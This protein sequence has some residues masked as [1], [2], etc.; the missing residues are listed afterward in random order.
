MNK[1]D[2]N[3]VGTVV[4]QSAIEVHR[5][6]GNGLL[7]SVYEAALGI[8]LAERGLRFQSQVP[9]EVFYRGR[10]LDQGFRADLIVEDLVILELK[11]VESV[12]LVHKKQIQTYLNLS[13]LRLGYLLNFGAHLMRKGIHRCVNGLPEKN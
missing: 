7:E 5:R 3:E 6:L 4:V 1:M 8:E 2:E 11:S 10:Q 13:G 12:S 9:I